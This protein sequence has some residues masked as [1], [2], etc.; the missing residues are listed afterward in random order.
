MSKPTLRFGFPQRVAGSKPAAFTLGE[1]CVA[2]A[3][4]VIFA[5]ATFATNQRLLVALKSQKETTAATMV[6]QQRMESF[7][8]TAFSN[9]ANRDYVKNNILKVRT[10]SEAPLGNLTEQFTIGVY[11]PDGSTNTVISW[12]ASHPNGQDI[13]Q[14]T[15]L[16]QA[17]L[18]RVDLLETWTSAN[19]RIRSRELSSIFGIG[20]IAP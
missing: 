1:V 3:V 9:I 12:D 5:G 8:A 10:G 19:G 11:P 2:I 7:R 16:A 14:N 4:A 18:L 15:N 6:M 13:S 20:N 17:T